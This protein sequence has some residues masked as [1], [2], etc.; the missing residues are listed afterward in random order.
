MLGGGAAEVEEGWRDEE[1]SR[2]SFFPRGALSG[3]E[4]AG[5]LH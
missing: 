3:V 4:G 1:D 2:N 5:Q